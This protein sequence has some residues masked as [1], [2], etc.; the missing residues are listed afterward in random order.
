VNMSYTKITSSDT[1]GK[2]VVG[3]PDTPGL[4]TEDMQKKFEELSNDVIIPKFNEL[5]DALNEAENSLH[6]NSDLIRSIRVN[7]DNQI[8]LLINGAWY[9]PLAGHLVKDSSG[10]ALTQEPILRFMDTGVVIGNVGN[11]TRV[12]GTV[13][14]KGEKGEKGDTGDSGVVSPV[15]TGIYTLFVDADGNLMVAYNDDTVP[16]SFRYDSETGNLYYQIEE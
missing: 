16:P 4:S 15:S 1:Y 14:E 13:G 2:G 3:L 6:I 5:V 12:Y 8:Q 7:S 10:N 9:T 11:E